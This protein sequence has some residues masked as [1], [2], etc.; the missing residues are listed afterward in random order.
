MLRILILNV[1]SNNADFSYRNIS[2]AFRKL[3]DKH[4][5]LKTRVQRGNTVPFMNL[6]LQKAI[7]ARSR[8]KKKFNRKPTAKNRINFQKQR[9]KRVSMRKKAMKSQFKKAT[10]N[11]IMSNKE[12]WDLVK[13]FFQTRRGLQIAIFLLYNIMLL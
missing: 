7:N 4:A 12:L 10:K 2:S 6:Q 9:N 13:P 11:G 8:L 1:E 3:V 5:P